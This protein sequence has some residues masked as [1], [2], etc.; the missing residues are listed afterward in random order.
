MK[1]NYDKPEN[2]RKK[3]KRF[4]YKDDKVELLFGAPK[5]TKQHW[6]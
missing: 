5:K 2:V 1:T 4:L 6:V 3:K